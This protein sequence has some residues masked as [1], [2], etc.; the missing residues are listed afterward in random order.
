[1]AGSGLSQGSRPR[2]AAPRAA[3]GALCNDG[4]PHQQPEH[5]HDQ[6]HRERGAEGPVIGGE[7]LG[8]DQVADHLEQIELKSWIREGDSDEWV[9]YQE[10]TIASIRPLSDLIEGSGLKSAGA[11][12]KAA[13]MLCGT[14]RGKGGVHPARS[15]KMAMNDP[16]RGLSITHSYDIV[17]LPEI[18]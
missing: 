14:F 2:C 13:A 5:D 10:G 6:H 8:V 7:E 15:F 17:E 11:S 12:G 1:M 18:A 3:R 9:P 16:V 4:L